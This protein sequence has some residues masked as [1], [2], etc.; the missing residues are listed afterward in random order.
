V[1]SFGIWRT[2]TEARRAHAARYSSMLSSLDTG[3][4]GR[5][6]LSPARLSYLCRALPGS[7][8]VSIAFCAEGIQSGLHYP[9]PVHLQKAHEDLGYRPGDFPV[10]EAAARSVL[11]LPIYPEMTMRRQVE[12]VVK[13]LEQD[14]YVS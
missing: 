10:S 7:R 9:I 4:P 14:A 11:S 1:S 13:A 12:Q 5:G 2:W 8:S 3:D 6:R